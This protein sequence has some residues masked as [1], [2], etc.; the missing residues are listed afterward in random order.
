M[1]V[2]HGLAQEIPVGDR[3]LHALEERGVAGDGGIA[4]DG[5]QLLR[6]TLQQIGHVFGPS[7][8]RQRRVGLGHPFRDGHELAGFHE[9]PDRHP[10]RGFLDRR[11]LGLELCQLG[12]IV[13][14]RGDQGIDLHRPVEVPQVLLDL[15]QLRRIFPR[16][17]PGADLRA[18]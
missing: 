8:F 17:G 4:P 6:Q 3:P 14:V 12:G 7:T 1:I 15:D 18:P 5:P 9:R 2:E 10:P 11:Q 16:D 13:P